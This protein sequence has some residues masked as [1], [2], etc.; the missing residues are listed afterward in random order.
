MECLI[1]RRT[2]TIRA[3]GPGEF[4]FFVVILRL[5]E[6][7]MV[8]ECE[9]LIGT[10]RTNPLTVMFRLPS[11]QHSANCEEARDFGVLW[12]GPSKKRPSNALD[13]MKQPH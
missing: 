2:V 9:S 5:L 13:S 4:D 6:I 3:R 11:H 10:I 12:R 1:T 8:N 7:Y